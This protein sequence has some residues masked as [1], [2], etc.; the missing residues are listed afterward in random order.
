MAG[1]QDKPVDAKALMGAIAKGYKLVPTPKVRA[2]MTKGQQQLVQADWK[3][4]GMLTLRE[5]K[6]VRVEGARLS[7][8]ITVTDAKGVA[9]ARK[10]LE[11]VTKENLAKLNEATAKKR[12]SAGHYGGRGCDPYVDPE[13]PCPRILSGLREVTFELGRS[14]F[15]LGHRNG[16]GLG[17]MVFVVPVGV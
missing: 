13:R 10:L 1:K 17:L 8:N 6:G 7:K 11:V 3:T 2:G 14:G 4:L 9:E 15:R 16:H 12:V 5:G